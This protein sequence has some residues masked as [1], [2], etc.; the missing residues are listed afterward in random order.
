MRKGYIE[1][2]YGRLLD[3]NGRK[4]IIKELSDLAM[5]FYIYGPKEDPLHRVLWDKDYSFDQMREFKDLLDFAENKKVNLYF[6]ISPGLS[7]QTGSKEDKKVLFKKL[8]DFINLGFKNFAL[9]MD[10]L[11][12]S[13]LS[14]VNKSPE[15]GKEHGLLA[16]DLKDFLFSKGA[17]NLLF[18]PTVYC[19]RFAKGDLS[20]S[21]YL[22]GLSNTIDKEIP[23]FWTGNEVVSKKIEEKEINHLKEIITNNEI[24][25]WD[26]FYAN[27][28]CPGRFYVGELTGRNLSSK[29]I[30]GMGLNITG[31]PYTDSFILNRLSGK[32]SSEDLFKKFKI[33][34]TFNVL[35]PF[36][37]NPFRDNK[38][39]VI[40]NIKELREVQH[41]ICVEWKNPIQIE[42]SPFLWDFYNHLNLLEKYTKEEEN[43][44]EDWAKR[45]YSSPIIE[46][47]K[48]RKK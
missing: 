47:I 44:L 37:D 19:K 33:P 20:S 26:N 16:N 23:I 25:I 12:F 39:A 9:F 14:E 22:E 30:L 38:D 28:Y 27:D 3:N 40:S 5:D 15:L 6:S 48:Q 4:L 8:G 35:A 46:I 43:A 45:R 18:C 31:L 21:K 17:D 34:E 7:M 29:S 24:I 42:W 1:G 13:Q 36:F 11:K 41:Q 10:D 32:L 2:Y